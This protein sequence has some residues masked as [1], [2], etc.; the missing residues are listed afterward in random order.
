MEKDWSTKHEGKAFGFELFESP[1]MELGTMFLGDGKIVA[2]P[3][4]TKALKNISEKQPT[5]EDLK[6]LCGLSI[7]V[8][9]MPEKVDYSRPYALDYKPT[10]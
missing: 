7:R 2:H 3:R 8:Y 1:V 6:C 5:D 4:L 9:P 10:Q